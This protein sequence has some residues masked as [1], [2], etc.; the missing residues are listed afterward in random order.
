MAW[1]CRLLMVSGDSKKVHN[2][3]PPPH[4]ASSGEPMSDELA[5]QMVFYTYLDQHVPLLLAT[6]HKKW[7]S[8]DERIGHLSHPGVLTPHGQS[9][10]HT[11]NLS[12]FKSCAPKLISHVLL[13]SIGPIKAH[14]T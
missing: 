8:R 13:C 7:I 6:D 12:L 2:S 9:R 14:C 3:S 1:S 5:G 4:L 11:K 10:N